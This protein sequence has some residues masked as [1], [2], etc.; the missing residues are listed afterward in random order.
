MTRAEEVPLAHHLTRRQLIVRGGT[1]ALAVGGAAALAGCG[2]SSSSSASNA[3]NASSAGGPMTGTLNYFTVPEWIGA[4]EYADFEKQ[5]PGLK[6]KEIAYTGSSTRGLAVIVR[7]NP[8]AYDFLGAVGLAAIPTLLASPSLIQTPDWSKVPNI[9][10]IPPRFRS[11]YPWGCPTDYGKVGFAYRKDLISDRPT[12][13]ADVWALAPKYSGKFVFL[14]EMEDCMGNTLKMLGYSGNSR[15][16]AQIDAAKNKLIEIKPHLQALLSENVAQPL[17]KGTASL[18]MD[19]DFD[20]ALAQQ[21]NKDI[22]WVTPT[23]GMMAYLEGQVLLAA[24]KRRDAAE[25][26]LNFNLAPVNYADFVNTTGTAYLEP[27]AT[28]MIKKSISGNPILAFTPAILAK[29][30]FEKDKGSATELWTT[31]WSE[32]EAA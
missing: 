5:H 10:Y 13:W 14:D 9:K 31:A 3:T 19:Y 27:A 12:S 23:E 28:P 26:F 8:G 22:V 7:E 21:Q 6:I 1:A 15:V 2:S 30:E 18:I 29:V 20:V 4:H 16:S 17:V 11:E 24:A 25:A 32:F